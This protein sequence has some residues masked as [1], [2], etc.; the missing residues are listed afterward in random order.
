MAIEAIPA[1]AAP[2]PAARGSES[3]RAAWRVFAATRVAILLVA[4]FAALSF[5]PVTG[6]VAQLNA[7]KFD[8]P[9]L[10][11]PLGGFGDT[12]LT[13]LARWDAVWYLRIASSG[14]GDSDV[15]AA[16]FPLYPGLARGLAEL[17]GGSHGALLISAYLV[18]LA[19]FLGALVLLY[20]L[21]A[22]EVGRAARPFHHPATRGLSRGAVL[23]GPLLGEPVPA[24]VRGRL[25]RRPHR[26]LGLGG[27]LRGGGLRHA[28]RRARA[29]AATGALLVGVAPAPRRRT[30]PGSCWRR[31]DWPPTWPCWDWP[32]ATPCASSRCRTPGRASS[33]ARSS[34]PGTDWSRPWTAPASSS[35]GRRTHVYFQQAGGDPFR[36]A[37]MNIMLFG[38]LVFAA[39]ASTG[40]WRRLPRAYGAYVVAALALPLSFPVE[41]QPLMSLPRFL[42][43]LFPIFMWLALVCDERRSTDLAVALSGIALGLFTAQFASWH[44]IA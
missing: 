31:S 29:A 27:G 18:S 15:R 4:V 24:P 40:L 35:P 17:A 10:T 25:L 36:V 34:A 38:F 16:F 28:Q 1:A 13:P 39:V 22:L 9:E 7:E 44:F 42:A 33:P 21:V 20:R 30:A 5:G 11:D 8:E 2:D 23:R 19:A 26:A 37:A 3:L 41:P 32:R 43:V 6:G 12:L 14:Y